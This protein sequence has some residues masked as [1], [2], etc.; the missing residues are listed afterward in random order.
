VT[1]DPGAYS[2]S[3]VGICVSDLERSLRFYCDGLGFTAGEQHAIGNEFADTLEVPRDV[4]LASQ[5]I[6]RDGLS[7]EL[8]HYSSPGVTGRPSSSRNQLGLTHLSFVVPDLDAAAA[9]LEEC[10]GT[11]VEST[12]TKGD[13]LYL[14]FVSDPDGTRVEL[15]QF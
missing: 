12:R 6:R 4:T 5:F 7:I 9:R 13:G 8:L 1:A 3:H 11:V 2:V 14:L 10:G 15:M